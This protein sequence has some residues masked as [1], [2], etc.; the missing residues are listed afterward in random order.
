M[1]G[2]PSPGLPSA[3]RSS[4]H[5]CR[6]RREEPRPRPKVA[7]R[8]LAPQS[9]MT[10]SSRRLG[11][12]APEMRQ[13]QGPAQA[14]RV[15]SRVRGLWPQS[16]PEPGPRRAGDVTLDTLGALVPR[17]S[18]EGLGGAVGG[19]PRASERAAC[20]GLRV[21]RS[22]TPACRARS[23]RR[24]TLRLRPARLRAVGRVLHPPVG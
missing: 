23:P 2:M 6:E 3:A 9:E 7:R 24:R 22:S 15:G 17:A 19:G 13:D 16:R 5:W 8:N 10:P 14:P 1:R 18:G 20:G 11:N 4:F 12:L 21:R